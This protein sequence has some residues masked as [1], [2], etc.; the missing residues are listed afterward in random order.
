MKRV[1]AW[2]ITAAIAA[3]STAQLAWGQ[4]DYPNRVVKIIV[5]YAAGTSPD[6][7]A[8]HLADRLM[9]A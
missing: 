9:P 2:L 1:T 5:P 4:A 8:R 6:V 3:L 7:V